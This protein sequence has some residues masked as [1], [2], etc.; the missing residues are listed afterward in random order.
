M[1]YYIIILVNKVYNNANNTK[2][3]ILKTLAIKRNIYL[4][5][6]YFNLLLDFKLKVLKYL[7]DL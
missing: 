7:V 2:L 5:L 4:K 6:R 3:L 1:C